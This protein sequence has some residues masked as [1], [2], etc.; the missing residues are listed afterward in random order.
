MKL[1]NTDYIIQHQGIKCTKKQP[2]Y[3][4]QLI[5]NECGEPIIYKSLSKVKRE[6]LKHIKENP[7]RRFRFAKI[8]FYTGEWN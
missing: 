8:M 5:M 2:E 7:L 3:D 4:V 6:I 1:K